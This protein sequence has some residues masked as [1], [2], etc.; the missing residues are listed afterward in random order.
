[1]RDR[2][3][4]PDL[5][6]SKVMCKLAREISAA[7]RRGTDPGGNV[8]LRIAMDR[9]RAHD[10]PADAIRQALAAGAAADQPELQ[11]AVYEGYGPGGAAIIVEALTEDSRRTAADV[12]RSLNQHGGHL[13]A[14]GS[15]A[16]LFNHVGLICFDGAVDVSQLMGAATEAGA[17]DVVANANGCDV[18]TAPDDFAEV[19]DALVMQ[20]FRPRF[21]EVTLRAAVTVRLTGAD[22][23]RMSRLIGELDAL[24]DVQRVYSNADAG[25]EDAQAP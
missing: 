14:K 8:R 7:A 1:M 10:M 21:A 5:R 17:E 18:L 4:V 22:A 9:A 24:D 25:V 20:G 15:V 2:E 11:Q 16:Y 6:R 19:R 12:R 23:A 13:G 3:V